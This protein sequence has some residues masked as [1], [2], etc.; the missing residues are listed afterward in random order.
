[1]YA[2]N[3]VSII[4]YDQHARVIY[5]IYVIHSEVSKRENIQAKEKA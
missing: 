2:I 4:P 3:A 5:M 1:M